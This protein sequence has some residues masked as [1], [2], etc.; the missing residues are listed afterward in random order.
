[1]SKKPNTSMKRRDFLKVA[2]LGSVAGTAAIAMSGGRSK[3]AVQDHDESGRRGQS[4]RE[5]AHVK[6]Y[7]ALA[8]F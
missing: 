8:K 5:T 1:M 2:G 3:A 4:Y 7:Y 6:Q